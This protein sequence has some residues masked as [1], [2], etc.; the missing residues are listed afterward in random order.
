[1]NSSPRRFSSLEIAIVRAL[2][3]GLQSKEIASALERSR[4]TI[5]FHIRVLFLKMDARSRA[6]LVARGYELGLLEH[7]SAASEPA[8]G[9]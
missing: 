8:F 2:A 7:V 5:E 4:P 1:M 6:Q 3:D 9:L